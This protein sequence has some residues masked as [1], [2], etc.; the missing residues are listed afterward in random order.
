MRKTLVTVAT[1]I[2]MLLFGSVTPGIVWSDDH[3]E[4]DVTEVVVTATRI[5]TASEN[6]PNSV[7]IITAEEIEQKQAGSVLDVLRSVPALD[8]AQQG[9]KGGLTSVFLR[10][11]NSKHTLVLLDG[12]ELNDP[13][14]PGRAYDLADLS[15][16]NVERIEILRGSAGTLY[17][18]DAVGGVIN[19]ITKKGQG[20]PSASVTLEGGSYGTGRAAV[21]VFGGSGNFNYSLG[22]S[23]LETGG[24]SAA[25]EKDGND[26]E[27]GYTRD[28]LA[29]R[30]G[31]EIGGNAEFDIT[32]RSNSGDKDLDFFAFGSGIED[33][34]NYT[35]S[36]EQQF[37]KSSLYLSLLD[38]VWDQTISVSA[39]KHERSSSD[40]PDPDHPFDLLRDNYKGELLKYEW[41]NDLYFG[42]AN[43]LT[44]GAEWEEE[45]GSSRDYREFEDFLNPGTSTSSSTEMAEKS[46]TNGALFVQDQLRIG[47]D[48]TITAGIRI[49]DNE[50]FG[51]EKTYSVGFISDLFTSSVK[52]RGTFGTGFKAPTLSELFDPWVGNPDL[53]PETSTSWDLGVEWTGSVGSLSATLFENKFED[54]IVFDWNTYLLANIDSARSRGVEIYASGDITPILSVTGSLTFTDAEQLDT[55]EDLDRRAKRKIGVDVTLRPTDN[56]ALGLNTL[57]VGERPD[58]GGSITLDEYT[59]VNLTGTYN[60]TEMVELF[61][62]VENLLDE[63]YQEVSGY[64][65]VGRSA[66]VG[67]RAGL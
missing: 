22:L 26:E 19:I 56:L 60:L 53:D 45:S 2:A 57:V 36:F 59:L 15:V 40:D 3:N 65:T 30:L 16:D 34:P 51:D 14:N 67:I 49:D 63:E 7:T 64:G 46:T 1:L 28:T 17:G 43:I 52:T 8:V 9:G 4:E 55:G 33:D 35:T 31:W 44:M 29:G 6:I 41:Q 37:L 54:L 11:T 66:Y 18:S 32:Y 25:D 48:R 42:D 27:D 5:E 38:G 58:E 39:S 12:M 50:R 13:I 10:G 47:D 20:E 61:G 21:D 24:I 62:R 23:R